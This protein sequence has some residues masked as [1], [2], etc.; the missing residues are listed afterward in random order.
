MLDVF[1]H[2]N[3]PVN[4]PPN[5]SGFTS[6]VGWW[7]DPDGRISLLRKTMDCCIRAPWNLPQAFKYHWVKQR[8]DA[9][10][11]REDWVGILADTDVIF[12]CSPSEIIQRFRS[13]G[14]PLVI[15]GERRW[16][17]L[18]INMYDP[19]GP[20]PNLSWKTRFDLRHEHQFY[21]NSGLIMG[22]R[23]GFEQLWRSLQNMSRFPCCTYDSKNEGFQ[24]G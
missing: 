1:F 19:F 24:M 15:G 9:A 12:Q 10:A 20:S 18:P 16:F 22:T 21:P 17:P 2:T 5:R 4:P 14:A 7:D 6:I 13:L 11:G 3:Q 8:I 23:D